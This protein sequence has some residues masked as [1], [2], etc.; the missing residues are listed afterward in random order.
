MNLPM[1]YLKM[2]I[3]LLLNNFYYQFPPLSLNTK[4]NVASFC[5]L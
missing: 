1:K 5:I 4:C 2:N 3:E